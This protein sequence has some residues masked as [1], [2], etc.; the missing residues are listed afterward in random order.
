[1]IRINLLPQKR[2]AETTQ[3]RQ[4]WLLVV[5][6][7]FLLEVG[8]LLVF[9]GMKA[10]E[11]EAQERRNSELTT[12]IDKLKQAV[13]NHEEVKAKLASLRAREDA[14]AKLQTARSGPT[15]VLLE[16]ARI[17]TV[18]RGPT[19][20]PER[21]VRERREN[22]LA[23][24]SPGWDARRL[25]ITKFAEQSRAVRL[26]GIARDGEDVSEIARR[27][28]LSSFFYDIRLLPARKLRDSRSGLDL[29]HFQLE[30]KVRY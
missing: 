13:Q 30:A 25:W 29:V 6:A 11:L 7:L 21:L 1:M 15:A 26:E 14:I 16:L 27:L 9:H 19:V 8:G 18:G 2:R 5:L 17:L 22:P 3:D 23:V 20:D 28:G 24:Y 10:D 12:Q 4:I